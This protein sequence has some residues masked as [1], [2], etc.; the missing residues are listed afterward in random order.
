[1][2]KQLKYIKLTLITLFIFGLSNNG[3]AQ[4]IDKIVA[5]VGDEIVLLS[6]LQEQK[7]QMI[8]QGENV[9]NTTDCLILEKILYQ[10]LLVNQAQIDSLEV[11]DDMVN[12]EMEQ[13]IAYFEEQIGGREKLEEFYGKSVAQIKA[14][15]FNIIKKRIL[16]EQMED[17]ITENLVVT[18]KDVKAFYNSLHKDSIPYINSK[19][20]VAHVVIYPEISEDDKMKAK[21]SLEMYRQQIVDGKKQFETI[22]LTKSDDPG[23]RLKEG[24]L[25]WQTRGTMVPEFEAALFALEKNEISPV[26]E[27]QYGF[28]IVQLLDRKGDNYHVRH[29]LIAAKS[30]GKAFEAAA[31]KL[32]QIYKD[33]KNN[34]ITFE[35]AARLFSTDDKSKNNGGKIVNPY[36][37]DY[38]WDIQNINEIDPQMYRII[39]R[40]KVGD[41]SS[42]SLYDNMYEQKSG[43]RIVKLINRTNPHKANLTD[44]YQLIQNACAEEKKQAIIK[45]WVQNKIEGAFIKIDPNYFGCTFNYKWIK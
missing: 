42:P 24:D 5:Q 4:V 15:F 32:D 23:S 33:I 3:N 20:S 25:G 2:K 41:F 14:E 28:H 11:S 18:P 16:A 40:M 43:V 22:A 36:T 17:K 30:N 10:K 29:I 37:S 6:D 34:K 44:D 39:D 9:S 8:Q 26:F 12:G 7:L 31:M 27:T 45:A 1:M 13:R 19:I 35:E 38:F 21:T